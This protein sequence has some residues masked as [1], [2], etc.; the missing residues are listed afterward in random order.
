MEA[1]LRDGGVNAQHRG[2][3]EMDTVDWPDG[4]GDPGNLRVDYLL[5]SHDLTVVDSAVLWPP[6]GNPLAEVAEQASRHRLIWLDIELG[7][8]LVSLR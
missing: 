2:P 3:A 1:A 7:E 6:A 5:P 4:P 8:G